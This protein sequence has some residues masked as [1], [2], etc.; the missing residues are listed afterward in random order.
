MTGILAYIVEI[1]KPGPN[2]TRLHQVFIVQQIRIFLRKPLT[3]RDELVN[4]ASRSHWQ[5][6]QSRIKVVFTKRLLPALPDAT[7]RLPD[8]LHSTALYSTVLCP[9]R[10][11]QTARYL[12][13]L[14]AMT[15]IYLNTP[16]APGTA[17][18]NFDWSA[19]RGASAGNLGRGYKSGGE[20]KI[21]SLTVEYDSLEVAKL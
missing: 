17:K 5:F 19:L 9:F 6:C 4:M 8:E 12:H 16:T 18:F 13:F 21:F 2:R 1:K 10:C 3:A 20:K 14:S 7:L 15:A 11:T